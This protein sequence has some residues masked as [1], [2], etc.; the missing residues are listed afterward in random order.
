M[1]RNEGVQNIFMQKNII[2]MS[3]STHTYVYHNI[4][5]HSF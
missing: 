4:H 2:A 5:I 1:K 3:I